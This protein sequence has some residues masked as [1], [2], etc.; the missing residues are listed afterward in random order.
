[1]KYVFRLRSLYCKKSR[2]RNKNCVAK[3]H[4]WYQVFLQ[5][6]L[7]KFPREYIHRPC[8]YFFRSSSSKKIKLTDESRLTRLLSFIE[9]WDNCGFHLY[10][11]VWKWHAKNFY[12]ILQKVFVRK[13]FFHRDWTV[14]SKHDYLSWDQMSFKK[15]TTIFTKSSLSFEISFV[16]RVG[17]KWEWQSSMKHF[18]V[19][20]A[21]FDHII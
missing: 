6:S 12:L 13:T 21:I 15:K 1:M 10:N 20:A 18:F 8:K 2:W 7:Q 4:T 17:H 9:F 16:F 3:K 5:E 14:D 19:C 11:F